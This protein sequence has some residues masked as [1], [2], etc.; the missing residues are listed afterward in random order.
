MTQLTRMLATISSNGGWA[1]TSSLRKSIVSEDSTQSPLFIDTIPYYGRF[2]MTLV[3]DRAVAAA[4]KAYQFIEGPRRELGVMID[5]LSDYADEI[6]QAESDTI[7]VA[8]KRTIT[9]LVTGI[10]DRLKRATVADERYSGIVDDLSDATGNIYSWITVEDGA[11]GDYVKTLVPADG[12]AGRVCK[13]DSCKEYL[14]GPKTRIVNIS[15]NKHMDIGYA[16]HFLHEHPESEQAK[17]TTEQLGRFM[18]NN[19]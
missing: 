16:D 1:K 10:L 19:L 6:W 17:K 2:S 4:C 14:S 5:S 13:I 18:G 8:E 3:V 12:F 15:T 7:T 11:Y 9:V